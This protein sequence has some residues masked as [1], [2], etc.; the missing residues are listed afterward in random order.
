MSTKLDN[1]I[2]LFIEDSYS[3]FNVREVARLVKLSPSTA[4]KYLN[5]ASKRGL[6]KKEKSRNLILFSGDLESQK[7][8]DIKIYNNI[9]KIRSSGLVEFIEKELN[10]PE[11]IILFGSY[12]KG[13][14]KKDS[15]I[16]LFILSESKNKPAL[17]IFE[18]KL[19]TE[20]QVFLHSRK[21]LE[22]MKTGN[23]ELLNNI[24]N[25]LRLSG[26]LEVF[27]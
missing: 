14:N 12:A 10:Y 2:E 19:G 20:I 1:I 26:F 18:K 15:D 9:K 13:E 7:F 11:V 21:D 22:R 3:K 16:D 5:D 24:A 25:G 27:K 8:R 23:K 17:D 4:S 6:L